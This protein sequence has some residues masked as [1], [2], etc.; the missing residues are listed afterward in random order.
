MNS[1][2]VLEVAQEAYLLGDH[3]FL[4]VAPVRNVFNGVTRVLNVHC[5]SLA[6]N[7]W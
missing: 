6:G 4:M 3:Q 5:V 7:T 2:P 1:R